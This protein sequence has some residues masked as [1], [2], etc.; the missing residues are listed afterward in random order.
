MV[1]LISLAEG[2]KK[3]RD[4]LVPSSLISAPMPYVQQK[5]SVSCVS[6]MPP[7]SDPA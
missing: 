5:S 3:G 7:M 2:E 1:R 6:A 4:A